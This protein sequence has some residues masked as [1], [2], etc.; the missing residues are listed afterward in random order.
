VYN[1]VAKEPWNISHT[2]RIWY[3]VTVIYVLCWS[4]I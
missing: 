4:K 2:V 1:F 3:W